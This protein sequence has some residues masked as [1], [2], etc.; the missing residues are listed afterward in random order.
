MNGRAILAKDALGAVALLGFV[1]IVLRL[2]FGLGA[3]TAL[4]DAMPWGLWK[5]LNMVAGVALATGGFTLACA[6]Y[7]LG[8]EKYRPL[9]RPA[10]LVAFLGY[11]SSCFALFLDIGLPHRIWHPIVHWNHHSFLF[12]VAWCVMLYFTVTAIE[13]APVILEKFP[14]PRLVHWLHRGTIPVVITGITLSTLHHS[15][16]GSLFLVTP[17]RLHELWYTSWLPVLFFVSAVGGG[18]MSVVLATHVYGWLKNRAPKREV[19]SGIA[20]A[21]AGALAL[22]VLLKIVDVARRDAWGAVVDGSPESL[23]FAVEVLVGAVLPCVLV[24]IPTVRR[25][26]AGLVTASSCAVGGLVLNRLN[27][28]IFGYLGSAGIFY[29]P[30]LP[31]WALSLGILSAAGL[32]FVLISERFDVFESALAPEPETL[33]CVSFSSGGPQPLWQMLSRRRLSHATL[34]PVIVIPLGALL[35]WDDAARGYPL[36]DSPVVPPM[37]MDAH[38]ASLRIDGDADGDYVVFDH[39]RHQNDL[40][41]DDSCRRC[42]HVF[43]PGD[44]HTPCYRCHTD[45][46]RSRSIF[47]HDLHALRIGHRL[48][49][50]LATDLSKQ[51]TTA[52]AASVR[53]AGPSAAISRPH[54]ARLENL[55]CSECHASGRPRSATTAKACTM[56]HGQ[57]MGLVGQESESFTPRAIGY[58]DALHGKCIRCH[59]KEGPPRGKAQMAECQTCHGGN[60][61]ATPAAGASCSAPS[62][63]R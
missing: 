42:H 59:E 21:A 7:V 33:V 60:R 54:S 5:I 9:L 26:A 55:S 22:L 12:E 18:M 31:E 28:G 49:E 47:D 38:R 17:S 27:V 52:V 40:G 8:L 44:P 2:L 50:S 39:A 20:V 48:T 57:D 24:A 36:Q 56:C 25:S 23:L 15:S 19:L 16:L 43:L 51:P 6:V 3:S 46:R 53:S 35:F 63:S 1:A 62:G 30:S 41:G 61:L 13:M 29:V 11:G 34:L 37:A 4:S 58:V 14:Y 32:L 10:I 45:M